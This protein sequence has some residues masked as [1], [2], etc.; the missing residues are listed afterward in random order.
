MG[1]VSMT[2]VRVVN[3]INV[4]PNEAVGEGVNGVKE[5][6]LVEDAEDV[7]DAKVSEIPLLMTMSTTTMDRNEFIFLEKERTIIDESIL[8]SLDNNGVV[9]E[10]D[11][12]IFLPENFSQREDPIET[13]ERNKNT[14]TLSFENLAKKYEDR[15]QARQEQLTE[16][17]NIEPQIEMTNEEKA[18]EVILEDKI[19]YKSNFKEISTDPTTPA[20]I[21]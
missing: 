3:V 6:T 21:K 18:N 16:E 12:S 17:K 5:T 9:I 2:S 7:I 20:N 14:L 1:E 10:E 19:S 15:Q 11:V 8:F 13:S 4:S